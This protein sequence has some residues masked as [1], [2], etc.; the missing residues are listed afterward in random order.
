MD[1]VFE[2]D[3]RSQV[4]NFAKGF[5]EHKKCSSDVLAF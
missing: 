2:I 5:N 1:F 4:T 3:K